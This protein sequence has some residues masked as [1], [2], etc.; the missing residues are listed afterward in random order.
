MPWKSS[1]KIP[2]VYVSD[3]YSK[4]YSP[5]P[6]KIKEIFVDKNQVV[7]KGQKLIELSSPELDLEISKVRR[8]IKLTKTKINRIS[9]LSNN[10]DQ[11]M[12]LQQRLISLKDELDG[13]SRIKSK[14]LL[15]S[16]VDG[17]IKNFSNLSNNQWVS[18]LEPL[19]GVIKSGPGN[20]IGYL[21]EKEI[22]RFK[23]NEKAVFIP[24]DGEHQKIKLI[25]KNLDRSAISILPY[26][27]LSS[28]YDGP[29][30]TRTFVSEEYENRPVNAH[31]QVT[32][33]IINRDNKIELEV[34]GYVHV[35]GYRYSPIF[36]FFRS[37]ISVIVRESR[38]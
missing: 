34:P 37:F 14:L 26:L 30:A 9:K 25:S 23:T 16:P 1:L 5:Y 33:Q 2:A 35:D 24:F 12:I 18:N 28:Q 31:Y 21:K 17:K 19:V 38:I 15:K 3:N 4:I 32:F 11:Y 8:K 27:S 10:L 13:L 6:A 29:I 36:D 20:V 7:K 22:K